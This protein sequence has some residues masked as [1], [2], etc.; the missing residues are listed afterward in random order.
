MPTKTTN[1]SLSDLTRPAICHDDEFI[2]AF[3]KMQPYCG[4]D[5]N[6]AGLIWQLVRQSATAV[7]R[8]EIIEVGCFHGATGCLMS[9]SAQLTGHVLPVIL[10]DTFNGVVKTDPVLDPNYSD[11]EHEAKIETVH[12]LAR[13]LDV[14]VLVFNGIFP[15]ETGELVLGVFGACTQFRFAHI[16][17]DTYRSTLDA[18][19]WLWPRM[20]QGGIIVIDDYGWWRCTGVTTLVDEWAVQM[21]IDRIGTV[22]RLP[23]QLQAIL[24]KL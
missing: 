17:V 5:V 2:A 7:A 14:P 21:E 18:L 22:I 8:G 12:K 20:A 4:V 15:D 10:C 9:K 3:T 11:G 16:D 6:R 24:V 13:L 1:P 19:T 23:H